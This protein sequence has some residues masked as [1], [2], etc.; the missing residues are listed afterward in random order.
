MWP[1]GY[2]VPVYQKQYTMSTKKAKPV[3]KETEEEKI[4]KDWEANHELISEAFFAAVLSKKKLPSYEYLAK[5]T[6]LSSKTIMRHLKDGDMFED[7]KIKLNALKDKALL[8]LAVKAINGDSHH[9]ARLFFEVTEEVKTK[10][11]NITIYVNGKPVG[12]TH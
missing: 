6:K 11:N 2:T 3:V 7:M 12:A 5:Q 10:D 1:N 9:W 8:T 4:R